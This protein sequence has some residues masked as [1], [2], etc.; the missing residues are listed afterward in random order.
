VVDRLRRIPLP[1]ALLLACAAI[2]GA[3]WSFL[4]PPL[5]GPDEVAHVT[6][7][8]RIVENKEIPW[9]RSANSDPGLGP[10][11]FAA[12]L[13]YASIRP[14]IQNLA[15]RPA[16]SPADEQLYYLASSHVPRTK[17]GETSTFV[18][19]PL[20]YL[21]EAVPYAVGHSGTFFTRALFMRL[22]NVVLLLASVV[23]FWLLAGEVL[24]RGLAQFVAAT[25]A[26]LIPQLL[27]IVGTV[28]ADN[29]LITL[30]SAALWL[31][32]VILRRGAT[33]GRVIG[34]LLAC[35]GALLTHGRGIPIFLPAG[36][37]LVLV[38]AR[39]RGWR[40]VTPLRVMAATFAV[41]LVV[42]LWW[43]SKGPQ[44]NAR[45]FISYVWQ[46]YL[47]KLGFMKPMIGVHY[48]WHQAWVDHLWSGYSHLEIEIP[49]NLEKAVW[50]GVRVGLVMLVAALIA[51]RRAVRRESA[52][53]VVLA[54]AVIGTLLALH[55]I[56]YR[57]MLGFSADPVLTGRYLLPLIALFGVAVG[58][59]VKALP[60][61]LVGPAAGLA[62]GGTLAM[63]FVAVGLVLERFYA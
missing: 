39:H 50:L 53:A 44:G 14:L 37:T 43:A 46:F 12:V 34:L 40:A 9:T 25:S 23:F 48:T 15:A 63:Q 22:A 28:N 27:N 10:S 1:L 30:W 54:S 55:L 26:A 16:W 56:A 13:A 59:V 52:S 3:A 18:N 31:M 47:P 32:V 45:E 62:I 36:M 6:Y 57:A 2:T 49:A 4:K 29:L 35:F 51:K 58:I 20:Y 11:E 19:P 17:G 21:Y 60:R 61:P 8:Q 42:L 41:Y 38:F 5:Q 7:V 24:G 33:R